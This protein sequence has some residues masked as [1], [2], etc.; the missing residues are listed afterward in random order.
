MS[1]REK[2]SFVEQYFDSKE[3]K[4][5]DQREKSASFL[6]HIVIDRYITVKAH[7]GRKAPG[8]S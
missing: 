8:N 7:K 4:E 2:S 3:G 1:K 6:A 5:K